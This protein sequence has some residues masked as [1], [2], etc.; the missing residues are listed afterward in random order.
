MA[1]SVCDHVDMPTTPETT[2]R[3][4]RA[5]RAKTVAKKRYDDALDA[6]SVAMADAMREGMKQGEV[7]ELTGYTREHVRRLVSK[8]EDERAAKNIAEP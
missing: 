3:L 1:T 4:K 7:V 6:L 5:V 2:D 8:V